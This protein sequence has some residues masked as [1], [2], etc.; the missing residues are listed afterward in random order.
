MP[1]MDAQAQL[2][3]FSSHFV[4]QIT[5]AP[6]A[7]RTLTNDLA[8]ALPST[9]MGLLRVSRWVEQPF[10]GIRR[11]ALPLR[12]RPRL[13]LFTGRVWGVYKRTSQTSTYLPMA[14]GEFVVSLL[15]LVALGNTSLVMSTSHLS[16]GN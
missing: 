11:Y 14:T 10:F 7:P 6:P 8:E 9:N 5:H 13:P 16:T 2:S 4:Q 12:L 1:P 3:R 15:E